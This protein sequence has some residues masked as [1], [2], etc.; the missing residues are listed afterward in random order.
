MDLKISFEKL[1]NETKSHDTA[2]YILLFLKK[3]T[4][5]L[6]LIS[7]VGTYCIYIGSQN[8]TEALPFGLDNDYLEIVDMNRKFA[9]TVPIPLESI[10]TAN[11]GGDKRVLALHTFLKKYNSPMSDINIAKAFVEEAEKNGFG[12]KWWLLPAIAGMES[13]FGKAIPIIGGK[14]SFNAWGWSGGCNKVSRWSCFESWEDAITKISRGMAKGYGVQNL[15]PNQIMARYCPPCASSGG[16]WAI[17]VN[18]FIVEM[19]RIYKTI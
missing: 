13:G 3:F 17:H 12:N 7:V 15:E 4:T 10:E 8:K 9:N 16:K 19:N 18:S 5:V 6:M 11:Q 14:S 2:D 1:Q